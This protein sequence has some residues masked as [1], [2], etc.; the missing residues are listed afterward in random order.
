[1]D[2]GMIGK[3]EKAK[4]YAEERNRIRFEAFRAAYERRDLR[5]VMG[6]FGSEPGERNVKGRR[7]IEQLYA[8]NFAVFENIHYDLSELGVSPLSAQEKFVVQ[9]RFRIRATHVG[10]PKAV[11]MSGPIRWL[12]RKEG[13]FFRIV[14]TD[15][16]VTSR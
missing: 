14:R 12:V 15:Y 8:R 13:G 9:G 16:E 2:Y 11:D 1:M 3:I 4:R 10:S 5:A 6:L 7:A